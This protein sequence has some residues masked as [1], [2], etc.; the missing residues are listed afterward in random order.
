MKRRNDTSGTPK[1]ED[2][3]ENKGEDKS[4]IICVLTFLCRLYET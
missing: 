3:H 1:G 2:E 4:N